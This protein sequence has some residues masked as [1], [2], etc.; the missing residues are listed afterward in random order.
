MR[1][2]DRAWL[3]LPHRASTLAVRKVADA[4]LGK[5]VDAQG[6]HG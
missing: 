4:E 2:P 6:K 5:G 1:K 3:H